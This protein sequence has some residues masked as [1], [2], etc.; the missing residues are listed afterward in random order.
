MARWLV[1]VLG[2][3]G[4]AWATQS[5][6]LYGAMRW[7]LGAGDNRSC[8]AL[9]LDGDGDADVATTS[10]D[11]HI[12]VIAWSNG[13]ATFDE[14]RLM[15]D[16]GTRPE[17]IAAG[18]ANGDGIVDLV[19][20]D[21]FDHTVSV[22]LGT[23]GGAFEPRVAWPTGLTPRDVALGDVDGDGDLDIVTA[24]VSAG[25]VTLLING[26]DG[27][28]RSDHATGGILPWSVETADLNGDG[29]DDVLAVNQADDTLSVLRA[30]AGGLAP[31]M[32]VPTGDQ[33]WDVIAADVDADGDLDV[34]VS[35]S[36]DDT[37]SLYVNHAGELSGRA[38]FSAGERPWGLAPAD[39][40][41]D[42]LTDVV[43]AN[44]V[45]AGV[46]IVHAA[47]G[48]TFEAPVSI[49]GAFAPGPEALGAGDVTGDGILDVVCVSR[50]GSSMTVFPGAGTD[51]VN[52]R[53]IALD[54]QP[55]VVRTADL[56]GDGDHDAV[57]LVRSPFEAR[58]FLN[59]GGLAGAGTVPAGSSMSDLQFGDLDD[60]G[61][62]D[63]IAAN[64]WEDTLTVLL[65][66][67]N[68]SFGTAFA[69]AT[70]DFPYRL[71]IADFNVDGIAD[72]AATGYADGVVA[73]HLGQGDGDFVL[74]DVVPVG[75][76]ARDI[77]AGDL[78][79]DG[80][81][82]LVVAFEDNVPPVVLRNLVPGFAPPV[83]LP[84]PTSV[85]D[86]A[87][88]DLDGDG[89]LDLAAA[90]QSSIHVFAND[91][92]AGMTPAEV[93]ETSLCKGV[94]LAD[95]DRDGHI[96][97][98]ST[99]TT[100]QVRPGLGGMTFGP[101]LRFSHDTRLERLD[102]ADIDA[103]GDL[104]VVSVGQYPDALVTFVDERSSCAGDVNQD[105]VLDV[106]DFIAFQRAWL[107]GKDIADCNDDGAFTVL[108]FVCFQQ[109]FAG[110]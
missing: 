5:P 24:N 40:N 73:I 49:D 29:C 89:D 45:N 23:G 106:L 36:A 75:S 8:V 31:A 109:V 68:A 2:C 101:A 90:R 55:V 77:A 16:V 76:E 37:V 85:V 87:M 43:I 25:S 105:G 94:D 9:D 103:D 74:D 53:S 96:D 32:T 18:D 51:L 41:H 104:D 7:V 28:V 65:N 20:A 10:H 35:D 62:V 110:C 82:D 19:C 108:D 47:P 84:E 1:V 52:P 99:C 107:A 61:D 17:G 14:S 102:V 34:V 63:M 97:I 4:G 71:A 60:D 48:A 92:D 69:R 44:R 27:F 72:V 67:G 64:P 91:G 79:G 80:A 98:V 3:A 11:A 56:D 6:P 66:D 33:P 15:L 12:V 30:N 78:D 39:F 42:G 93:F 13:D 88:S 38:A 95:V 83:A 59:D 21:R 100:L 58:L 81:P 86:L 54:Q 22:L 57:V 26:G 70:V 50:D 46:S